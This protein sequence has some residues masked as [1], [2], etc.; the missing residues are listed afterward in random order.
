MSE[1]IW[2]VGLEPAGAPIYAVNDGHSRAP[3]DAV[4]S[5]LVRP[6]QWPTYY[7]NA[8]RPRPKS[9]SWPEVAL[10]S[11]FTWLTFGAPCT[12]TVTEFEP[13]ERFAFT[14]GGLGAVGH[15]AWVLTDDGKG[16]TTIHTEETQRGKVIGLFGPLLQSWM[17]SQ[18][19]KWVDNLARI[20]ETGRRP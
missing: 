1:I 4:W 8:R 6:D 7:R 16:G 15:H 14:G 2:P 18:H 20:A 9:G 5:W 17:R 13:L 11:T 12:S 10:G 19:Q 3:R